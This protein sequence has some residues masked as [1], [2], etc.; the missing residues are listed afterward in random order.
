MEEY[1]A[2]LVGVEVWLCYGGY[3]CKREYGDCFIGSVNV[4]LCIGTKNMF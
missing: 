3:D 4:R 2:D 1:C